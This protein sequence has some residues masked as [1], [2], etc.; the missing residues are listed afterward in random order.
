MQRLSRY[1]S[2]CLLALALPAMA[3]TSVNV[4]GLFNGKAIVSIN[5]GAPETLSVGQSGTDGVKLLAASS[6]QATLLVEGKRQSLGMGQAISVARSAQESTNVDDN[7]SGQSVNLYAVGG[8]HFVAD[9]LINGRSLKMLVDTG[10]T[11]VAL[12]SGDAKYAGIDYQR[13]QKQMVSTASGV[14]A[15]YSVKIN[16]LKIGSMVFH[17]V[18]A[19]VLEGGFPEI[20]LL[21]MS[22]LNRTEMTRNGMMLTLKKKF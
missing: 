5:S 14:T 13:G 8:G 20:A 22:V 12:N 6:N 2:L 1:L 19:M 16:T 4:V 21:G 18:D 10:A 17:N 7:N 15:A 11:S 3:A 9:G